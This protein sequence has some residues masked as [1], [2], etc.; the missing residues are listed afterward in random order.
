MITWFLLFLIIISI[1][2]IYN[3]DVYY[4]LS[5]LNKVWTKTDERVFYD[6]NEEWCKK[7]K[8]QL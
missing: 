7:F 5:F 2:L 3:T 1:I 4:F 6:T 8:R